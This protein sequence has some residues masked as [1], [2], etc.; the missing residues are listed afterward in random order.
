MGLLEGI[1]TYMDIV[2]V[3]FA[4]LAYSF[5]LRFIKYTEDIKIINQSYSNIEQ[6][7]MFK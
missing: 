1:I 5:S 3:V 6:S 2:G 4:I 7:E